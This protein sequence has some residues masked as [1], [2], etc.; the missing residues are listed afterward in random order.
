MYTDFEGH[1]LATST[2]DAAS[3]LTEHEK[4]AYFGY[5][6]YGKCCAHHHNQED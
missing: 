2:A 6:C 1:R 3:E 5:D 4:A